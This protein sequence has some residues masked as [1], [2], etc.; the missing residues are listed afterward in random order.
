MFSII[1]NIYVKN[2]SYFLPQI[3]VIYILHL[4][5]LYEIHVIL[6]R[7]NKIFSINFIRKEL[8]K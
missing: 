3:K 2:F 4:Y 8:E 5:F 1:K 7:E 6:C